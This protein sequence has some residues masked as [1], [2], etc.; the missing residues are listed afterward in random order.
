M[1]DQPSV[2]PD[3]SATPLPDRPSDA[4][5]NVS[6][7][8]DLNTQGDVTIEGDVVGRDKITEIVEGDK[9]A[10]DKIV[11]QQ[12][13]A[14]GRGIAIGKLNV[15][16]VPLVTAL[17]LGLVVLVLIGVAVASTQQQVQKLQPTPTPVAM[18]GVF[19][20]IVAEFSEADASG[21]VQ[22]SERS[23]N[24][25][26]TV[27]NALQEQKASFPDPTARSS[28]DLRYGDPAATGGLVHDEVTAQEAARRTGALMIIYGVLDPQGNFVPRFY[29]VPQARADLDALNTGDFQFGDQSIPIGNDP[30]P[31]ANLD[32][33]T[34][35]TALLYI[36]MGLTYDALGE[37]G[38]S[39]E[40]YQQARDRLESW[41]DVG[42]GKEVLYFFLGQA[43]FFKQF[44]TV[45][46]EVEKLNTEA[47]AAFQR[48]LDIKPTYAR[49]LIGLGSVHAMR[50]QRL[51]SIA[52]ALDGD[53]MIAMF[54]LYDRA[55]LQSQQAGDKFV[56]N[57]ALFS[58]AGAY[59]LQ[60]AAYRYQNDPANAVAS[61]QKAS[62]L[63]RTAA[64]YF[65][66]ANRTRELAQVYLLQGAV[67]KQQAETIGAQGDRA[68]AKPVY[69]EAQKFY[70]SCI[71][72]KA[73][74]PQD[75]VLAEVI[76]TAKCEPGLQAV[77]SALEQP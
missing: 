11:E 9:V 3:S 15:P 69:E 13:T 25:T 57:L 30:Q 62:D 22:S 54:D 14:T 27:F 49:A 60:G 5:T 21:Q 53:D 40:V 72:Q 24:L 32:L 46:D 17:G 44:K 29:V 2:E 33:Q 37:V 56:E 70:Q 75:R 6:G 39:L 68:G 73:R 66:A 36:I 4:T 77:R 19:N 76:V 16:L 51:P 26:R 31:R 10:G 65:E 43:A 47:E 28:V 55:L 52:T 35:S 71:D 74:A 20:V 63:N 7:G 8:V 58:Q 34:R 45:G 41:S 61:F 42:Q 64:D 50:I 48:A 59:Y 67:H 1:T 23:R 18:S 12:I 38:L